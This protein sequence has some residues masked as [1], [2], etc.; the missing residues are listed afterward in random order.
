MIKIYFTLKILIPLIL[1]GLLICYIIFRMAKFKLDTKFKKNCYDCKY[2]N[3][4][5]VASS[6]NSCRYKCNIKNRYDY[7]S[8]ND[9]Y[10]LV[11]CEGF[12]NK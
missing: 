3:L 8:M 2:Y 10:N 11:K 6:D 1:I 9:K 7:H 12:K 5:D 4:F